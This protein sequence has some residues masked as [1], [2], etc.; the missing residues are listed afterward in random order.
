MDKSCTCDGRAQGITLQ[1]SVQSYT[2][3][4]TYTDRVVRVIRNSNR[5]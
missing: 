1:A 2:G 4:A 5:E 3:H